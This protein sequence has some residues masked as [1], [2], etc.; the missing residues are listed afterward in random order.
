M[1]ELHLIYFLFK[2]CTT[3][4]LFSPSS[5]TLFQ[6]CRPSQATFKQHHQKWVGECQGIHVPSGKAEISFQDICPLHH[7]THSVM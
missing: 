3:C 1:K 2:H 7:S 6:G 4:N 5:N